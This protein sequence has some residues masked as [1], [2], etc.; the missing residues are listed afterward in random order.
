VTEGGLFMDYHHPNSPWMPH[1]EIQNFLCESNHSNILDYYAWKY[2]KWSGTLWICDVI[3][4]PQKS[5]VEIQ[6]FMWEA[7]KSNC[8]L[9]SFH[10]SH[11]KNPQIF[12]SCQLTPKT[13]TS[14]Q[15]SVM[16]KW[17]FQFLCISH[18]RQTLKNWSNQQ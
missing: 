4:H 2:E 6:N 17:K 18:Q 10:T 11:D 15:P 13:D 8:R 5:D 7:K 16:L 3:H 9:F 14:I 12:H 1:S